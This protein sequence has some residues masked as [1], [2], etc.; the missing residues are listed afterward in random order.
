MRPPVI[1]S[2][3][4]SLTCS[5]RPIVRSDL[6]QR[7]GVDHGG[8]QLGQP[9]LGEVGVGGVQRL[10]HDHAEHG[11]AEELQA[12]VGRAARRSRRR[13]TGASAH[14]RAARRPGRVRPAPRAGRGRSV[15]GHAEVTGLSDPV[16]PRV[17]HLRRHQ[18]RGLRGP[19]AGSEREPYCPQAGRRGAAGAWRRTPG[20]RR[21]PARARRPSTASG[22][23]GCCCATSS[24]S[25]QP[26]SH[27]SVGPLGAT[28]VFLARVVLGRAGRVLLVLLCSVA[29]QLLQRRPPGVDRLV[30]PVVRVVR[31]PR[32]ALGAQSR[33]V[34]PAQRL[35]R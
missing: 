12:L 1:S 25:G 28:G 20:W 29:G 11:V 4:P 3:R 13:R 21:S 24:A 17:V 30:V 8:A 6:G 14:A 19:A 5:P 18:T 32:A 33:T 9:T 31:Q 16:T 7:T 27:S 26:R 23:G 2:P 15:A 22:G 35:E 34:V 10:G